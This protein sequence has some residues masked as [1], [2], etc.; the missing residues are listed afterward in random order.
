[1]VNNSDSNDDFVFVDYETINSLK[2]K[3]Q[4]FEILKLKNKDLF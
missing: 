4:D 1:M 2:I 3:K